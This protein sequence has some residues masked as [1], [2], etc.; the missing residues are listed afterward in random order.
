MVNSTEP[1][2]AAVLPSGC[3]IPNSLPLVLVLDKLSFKNQNSLF[4]HKKQSKRKKGGLNSTESMFYLKLYH[5]L[6]LTPRR[7]NSRQ[8]PPVQ[9]CA[10]LG[11]LPPNQARPSE[12]PLSVLVLKF[13]WFL[14]SWIL[15]FFFWAVAPP[16]RGAQATLEAAALQLT[17]NAFQ[18]P[19]PRVT[20]PQLVVLSSSP[21]AILRETS[22]PHQ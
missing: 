16:D 5:S 1:Q 9:L 14:H 19:F 6:K 15:F 12:R 4:C 2:M 20:D 8:C 3:P 22:H 18:V 21:L 11:F 10:L 17:S 13:F 7:L